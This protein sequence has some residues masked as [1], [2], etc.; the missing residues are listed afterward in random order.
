MEKERLHKELIGG[1]KVIMKD[2]RPP[3]V[4]STNVNLHFLWETKS[5]ET[6]SVKD[7]VQTCR[8]SCS[9]NCP[10]SLENLVV[11]FP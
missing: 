7:Y 6:S 11:N 8:L 4:Y 9:Y 1:D 10:I 2:C 5:L 3:L